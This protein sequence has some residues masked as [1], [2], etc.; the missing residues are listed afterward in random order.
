MQELLSL[1]SVESLCVWRR[2]S[3]LAANVA[4]AE[5]L[6][7]V[8]RELACN[9]RFPDGL[10]HA[11]KTFSAILCGDFV[12]N[13]LEP[14]EK[15]GRVDFIVPKHTFWGFIEFLEDSEDVEYLGFVRVLSTMHRNGYKHA[16]DFRCPEKDGQPGTVVRIIRSN[17]TSPLYSVPY[18]FSTHL[19]NV[20]THDRLIVPYPALTFARTG[21]EVDP[22]GSL[23]QPT[24]FA[25][26]DLDRIVP[27]RTC[28]NSRACGACWRSFNDNDCATIVFDGPAAMEDNVRWKLGGP[29]CAEYCASDEREV[30]VY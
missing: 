19:M 30:V 7:R 27:N 3:E 20:I 11:M 25:L 16:V 13:V 26:G 24:S 23:E 8:S 10:S 28:A 14:K 5:V 17:A 15:Y 21:V 12:V 4:A 6:G 29:P 18:F 1:A 22:S 9:F 2:S